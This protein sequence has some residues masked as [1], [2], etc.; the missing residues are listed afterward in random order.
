MNKTNAI[1]TISNIKDIEKIDENTK[2][3]NISIDNIDINVID[4]FLLNGKDYL[5]SES[6]NKI[7]GFIYV[8]YNTFSNGE[9]LI[10]NII[11]AM[12]NNLNTIEKVRYL[13]ITIG[14]LLC[15]DINTMEDKNEK[16]LF[17]NISTINNIWGSL[18][19]RKT[20]NISA[21]KIFMYICSRIG[22]KVELV[23]S[24]FNSIGNKVY[25]SEKNY[26]VVDL[27]SDLPYIQGHFI[28][29]NFDKYNNDKKLDIK[30]GYIDDE[31]NNYYL[32]EMLN[33]INSLDNDVIDTILSLSEKVLNIDI[34]GPLEL[35]TI[36]KNIF[37]RYIPNYDIR[38]NNFYINDLTNKKHFIVINY[39]DNY[40]SYNY[41]KHKF[42]KVS[43]DEIYNNLENHMIGL[44]LD[45][46]FIINKKEAVL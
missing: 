4:Y 11:D 1:V 28:T 43:Y 14:K 31:Y 15:S 10:T 33:N 23:N 40:Y 2:Y 9:K 26:V 27:Y 19:T 29:K 12:P 39:G 17:S 5:Y 24:S 25:V 34:I 16:V 20:S 42:I 36:Y 45:E 44:Y 41:T 21:S 6:I 18:N 37:N 13:Y 35:S 46:N 3:I 32:D 7:N 30:I 38:I 22:I 8:D